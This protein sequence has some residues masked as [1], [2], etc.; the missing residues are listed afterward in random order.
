MPQRLVQHP[1][2]HGPPN[3]V[4]RGGGDEYAVYVGAV[5]DEILFDASG[6]LYHAGYGFAEEEAG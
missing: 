2:A 5:G 4:L 6:V 3:L 1:A